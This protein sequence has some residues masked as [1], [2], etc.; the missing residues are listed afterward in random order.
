MARIAFSLLL[1]FQFFVTSATAQEQDRFIQ[2]ETHPDLA[3]TR[4]AVQAYSGQLA[5]VNGFSLGAGWYAVALGPYGPG[6]AERVMTRL[7]GQGLIPPGSYLATSGDYRQQFWPV[8]TNYLDRAADAGAAQADGTIQLAQAGQRSDSTPQII[9]N[10]GPQIVPVPEIP[11][12]TTYEARQNERRLSREERAQLQVA[13]EWAGFYNGPIDAVIGPGTRAAMSQWQASNDYERTGVMTSRQRAELL[14]QYNSVLEGLELRLVR[15]SRTG[16]QMRM[17]TGAVAFSRYEPPFAHFDATGDI[18]GARVL[19][20]SQRGD[21]DTLVGLYD[22]MQTLRIVPPEGERGIEGDSFRL[23]GENDEIVSHTEASVEGGEIK[24]FTLIWPAGDEERRTR[25]LNEMRASFERIA[26]VLDPAEGS[27]ETQSVDLVSGLEIRRPSLSRSGFYVDRSGTVVTTLEVVQGCDRVTLDEDYDARVVARDPDLGVAVLRPVDPLAPIGIAAFQ[28]APPRLQSDVAAAGYSYGGILGA[29][30]VTY[31]ELAD[32]RGL[33]GEE[34]LKRLALDALEGDAGGPVV[35][36]SGAVLGML[37][38]DR[39]RDRQ[40]PE[41]V[42]FAADAEAITALLAEIG[43]Q[44]IPA[45]GG[46][47]IDPETLSKRA[48]GMTVLVSCWD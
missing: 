26:G 41:G 34:K 4:Q 9:D 7:R 33:N 23:V 47:P 36:S 48:S 44:P 3:L 2:I 32:V 31:G 21:R 30:T 14:R 46:Q 27:G 5:D 1:L 15:D 43:V 6:E 24:G 18:P 40:L 12:E 37:L 20:I 19:L 10:S 17:P 38:P 29:P 16:I 28:L 11:A 13:L 22:I 39:Q 8:G 42:S 35:D 45:E 25:L